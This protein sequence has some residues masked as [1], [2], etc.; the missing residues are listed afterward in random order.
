VSEK[1]NISRLMRETLSRHIV[2]YLEKVGV[3]VGV[4]KQ[5][6]PI[7]TSKRI[8]YGFLSAISSGARPD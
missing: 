4:L 6:F 2:E 1:V 8:N 7:W 5:I 3:A